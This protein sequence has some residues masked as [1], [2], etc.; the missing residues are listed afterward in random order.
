MGTVL[1]I[2]P[3]RGWGCGLYSSAAKTIQEGT[4]CLLAHLEQ[5]TASCL[6][7]KDQSP[8]ISP[9]YF[10]S[11]KWATPMIHDTEHSQA[12]LPVWANTLVCPYISEAANQRVGLPSRPIELRPIKA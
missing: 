1:K 2:W 4:L 7:M 8:S 11:V 3:R 5:S 6:K 9:S 10:R 12:R